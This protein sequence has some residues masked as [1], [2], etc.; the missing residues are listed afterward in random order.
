[1]RVTNPVPVGA[2][3][4]EFRATIAVEQTW[5]GAVADTVDVSTIAISAACGISFREGARFI[6]YASPQVPQGR[7]WTERC[8]RTRP[9]SDA[10]WD[11]ATLG[12]A[13]PP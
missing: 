5:K 2:T 6:V 3:F 13:T 1:V 10:Q 8:M 7:L 4:G 9:L 11:L 12:P